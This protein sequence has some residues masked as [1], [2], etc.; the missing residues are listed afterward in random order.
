MNRRIMA[1]AMAVLAVLLMAQTCAASTEV[2]ASIPIGIK[3]PNATE[4]SATVESTPTMEGASLS[5][6]ISVV[7]EEGYPA[8]AAQRIARQT[9][10]VHIINEIPT[11]SAE[12]LLY[13]PRAEQQE[14]LNMTPEEAQ[15]QLARYHLVNLSRDELYSQRQVS[16]QEIEQAAAKRAAITSTGSRMSLFAQITSLISRLRI[17]FRSP[18]QSQAS[19]SLRQS[20][21]SSLDIHIAML[22][23]LK[24]SAQINDD[25]TEEEAQSIISNADAKITELEQMSLAV[26]QA[27]SQEDLDMAKVQ[28]Q[29]LIK[30][31]LPEVK[32]QSVRLMQTRLT[33]VVLRDEEMQRKLECTLSTMKSGGIQTAAIDEKL[34]ELSAKVMFAKDDLRAAKL[35]SHQ[36]NY[37]LAEYKTISAQSKLEECYITLKDIVRDIK[38]SNGTIVDCGSASASTMVAIEDD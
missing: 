9:T 3:I 10:G 37:S 35:Y 24:Y 4:A 5:L 11:T 1:M 26:S 12:I 18:G 21:I 31:I 25:L 22:E 14:I 2:E 15:A 33:E 19:E 34:G 29:S 28:I 36:A 20:L 27:A 23:N 17:S 32:S 8:I 30:N 38:A 6:P 7:V 13:L 16:A